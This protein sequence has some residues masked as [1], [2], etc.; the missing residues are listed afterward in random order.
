MKKKILRDRMAA[1]LHQEREAHW[2]ERMA[3]IANT[4]HTSSLAR[5]RREGKESLKRLRE[6]I[7]RR[8]SPFAG[9]SIAQ[10]VG[11]MRAVREELWNQ[12]FAPRP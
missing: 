12:K 10:A 8:P 7:A 3:L 9:L 1:E 5:R 6:G 11:R 2:E 4:S